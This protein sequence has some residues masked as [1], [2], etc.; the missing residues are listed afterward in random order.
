MTSLFGRRN[1]VIFHPIQQPRHFVTIPQAAGKTFGK[2]DIS[3][4][5]LYQGRVYVGYG[6][7][8]ANNGP[9]DVVSFD[10]D[11]AEVI[12]HLTDVPTEAIFP[13]REFDGWLYGPCVDPSWYY[14][15]GGYVTNKGGEWHTVEVPDMVHTFDVYAD[16]RGTFVCGSRLDKTNTE[17]GRAVVLFQPAGQATWE[18][19]LQSEDAGDYTR[20]YAFTA[21]GDELRVSYY[22]NQRQQVSYSSL[23]GKTWTVTDVHP[24]DVMF[25]VLSNRL[26]VNGW[27]YRGT[28][29]GTITRTLLRVTQP[30]ILI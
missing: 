15:P 29:E 7:Y 26:I 28:S 20:F 17:V 27:E 21:E 16:S 22:N 4:L 18:L 8:G 30:E 6:D 9:T 2:K 23:D 1:G 19:V 14:G 12:T 3:S 5:T 25:P 24:S 11:T 13:Y 10:P